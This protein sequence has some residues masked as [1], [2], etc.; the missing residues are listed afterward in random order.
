M[1]IYPAMDLLDGRVVFLEKGMLSSAKVYSK[2]PIK[3]AEKLS[4][5]G[6]L[7]IVDLNGAI[8]GKPANLNIIEKIVKQGI[9]VQV[10]GG[11]RSYELIKQA[12]EIGVENVIV[13]TRA[14]DLEFIGEISGKFN[15]IT[16]SLDVKGNKIVV[17]GWQ[18]CLSVD[19]YFAY[20]MLRKYVD[21]FIY[22]NTELDGTLKGVTLNF[23][24]F[25]DDEEFIYAGGVV[26][27]QDIKKLKNFGFD[28]VIIGKALY[29]GKIDLERLKQV[30]KYVG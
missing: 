1:R 28:G 17:N 4:K 16:V 19:A 11:F 27:M 20:K 6:K 2:D 30:A 10:G 5:I 25:W 18:N 22:T 21:R 26:C 3:I 13:S 14:L 24:K 9:R 12:Y 15:G 8:Y 7:H 29:E 23:S